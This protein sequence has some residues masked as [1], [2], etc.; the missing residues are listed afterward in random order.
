[1]FRL[2][3]IPLLPIAIA[4]GSCGGKT[5]PVAGTDTSES[6]GDSDTDG[7]TDEDTGSGG[8]DADGDGFTVEEGDCDD[9]DIRVNPAREEDPFDGIDN[10][11]DGRIDEEWSGLTVAQQSRDRRSAIVVFDTV[12][13][14]DAEVTLPDGVVPYDL[15]HAVEGDGWVVSGTELWSNISAGGASFEYARASLYRVDASGNT[16]PLAEFSDPNWEE[17]GDPTAALFYWFGPIIRGVKT[18][19]GGWY[20]VATPDA[21]FRVDPSGSV[22]EL[23]RWGGNITSPEAY[24]LYAIDLTID[25]LTGEI[26]VLGLLGGFGTW[27]ADTGMVFHRQVDISEGFESWDAKLGVSLVRMDGDANYAMMADYETGEYELLAWD[28]SASDW[29]PRLDWANDLLLPLDIATDGDRG[30]W[31]A[32]SK[33]GQYR[34]IWKMRGVDDSIDDF[35][36]EVEDGFSYWGIVSNW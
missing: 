2:R 22:S 11:C 6:D 28:P 13:R 19:P 3:L 34:T 9:E 18:H 15:D 30:D 26:S 21:L 31:F 12:S 14:I 4:V 24:D 33:G 27:S 36:N 32:T 29:T 20:A 7:G 8:T 35:Y 16:T 23:A 10:D 1:M 17:G 5:G 25:L